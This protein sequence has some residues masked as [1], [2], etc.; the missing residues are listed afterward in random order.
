[1]RSCAY[2]LE[3]FAVVVSRHLCLNGM[4]LVLVSGMDWREI[5]RKCQTCE[6]RVVLSGDG[7]SVGIGGVGWVPMAAHL[8]C[9]VAV[10]GILALVLICSGDLS[11]IFSFTF[12]TRVVGILVGTRRGPCRGVNMDGLEERL[13][14]RKRFRAEGLYDPAYEQNGTYLSTF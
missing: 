11:I 13:R 12:L 1:M 6:T 8:P 5:R 3:L 9:P 7:G 14:L 4:R 2:I 10:P